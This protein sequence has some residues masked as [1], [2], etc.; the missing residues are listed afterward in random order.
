MALLSVAETSCVYIE[1]ALSLKKGILA[2]FETTNDFPI[3]TLRFSSTVI[4]ALLPM[5]LPLPI[6]KESTES[7]NAM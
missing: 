2:I 5:V 3:V 6:L 1:L 4:A 7:S